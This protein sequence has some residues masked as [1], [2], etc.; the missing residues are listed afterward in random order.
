ML[1]IQDY[2]DSTGGVPPSYEE[3]KRHLGYRSKSGA[4]RVIMDLMEQGYLT[5]GA[6]VARR[7]MIT[8]RLMPMYE[9]YVF[10]T[11]TK[12]FKRLK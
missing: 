1:F 12:K 3:I 6:G 9:A 8:R 7:M 10:N 4:H 11:V 2:V 5:M